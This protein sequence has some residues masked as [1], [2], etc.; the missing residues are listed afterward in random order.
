[1]VISWRMKLEDLYEGDIDASAVGGDKRNSESD[2]IRKW[3][4]NCNE[5]F[6]AVSY[7]NTG[8]N[9]AGRQHRNNSE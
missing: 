9:Y 5:I 1:M 2:I 7:I 3:K 8:E 6:Q 4:K